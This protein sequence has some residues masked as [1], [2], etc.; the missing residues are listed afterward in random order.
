MKK[1]IT[2][3][4]VI[5]LVT[6]SICS[7]STAYS[8]KHISVN[9]PQNYETHEE[10]EN[11]LVSK[12]K[13]NG[14]NISIIEIMWEPN[15]YEGDISTLSDN[16]AKEVLEGFISGC[17]QSGFF[18]DVKYDKISRTKI[19]NSNAIKAMLTGKISNVTCY[20]DTYIITSKKYIYAICGM[21]TLES[22]IYSD[23]YKNIINSIEISDKNSIKTNNNKTNNDIKNNNS[24]SENEIFWETTAKMLLIAILFAII[25]YFI[26]RARKNKTK[27]P[28]TKED[29]TTT[30][31]EKNDTK[32]KSETNEKKSEETKQK[33]NEE[34]QKEEISTPTQR[35]E[36]ETKPLSWY[37]F[38]NYIIIPIKIII[39]I[40][41]LIGSINIIS[42]AV[43]LGEGIIYTFILAIIII[44]FIIFNIILFNHMISKKRGTVRLLKISIYTP[45]II[46]I[47]LY[48]ANIFIEI[49][50]Q[51]FSN[52]FAYIIYVL[53]T[54]AWMLLN[55][56]YFEDR[57]EIFKN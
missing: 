52:I 19:N 28:K 39:Y 6:V 25:A 4:I 47:L 17:E 2:K 8:N 10:A 38:Y 21:T 48:I 54:S 5:F 31:P 16:E 3:L 50:K 12:K 42:Q 57:E 1:A 14:N 24:K 44:P 46:N 23:E 13:N 35:K 45:G 51:N 9:F 43:G 18:Y 41:I 40:Y 33:S 15:E 32:E 34:S 49:S 56:S 37:K 55:V 20:I 27:T 30:N 29:N 7:Y 53:I 36:N 26:N 22:Y 11:S